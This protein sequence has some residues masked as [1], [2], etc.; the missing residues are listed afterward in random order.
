M[1]D[2]ILRRAKDTT[3]LFL[4]L[5]LLVIAAVGA[6]WIILAFVANFTE[7]NNLSSLPKMPAIKKAEYQAVVQTTGDVLL[8]P[9]FD[10]ATSPNDKEL[11]LYTL[12]GFYCV[13]DGKW[14]YNEDDFTMDE[15]IWGNVKISKRRE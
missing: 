10:T 4:L 2:E 8:T 9:R 13:V 15:F 12:H 6:A 3:G 7:N 5:T 11:Q 14:Q 1:L